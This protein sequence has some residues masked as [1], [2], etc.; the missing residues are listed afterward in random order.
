MKKRLPLALNALVFFVL[1]SVLSLLMLLTLFKLAVMGVPFL[2]FMWTYFGFMVL[3]VIF[4][5]KEERRLKLWYSFL[6]ALL[7]AAVL[8]Y[9]ITL[10][11]VGDMLKS[12]AVKVIL[13]VSAITAL[14]A[15]VALVI[16]LSRLVPKYFGL[17]V[18]GI[19]ALVQK[20]S[21]KQ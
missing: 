18:Q 5:E 19:K 21:D 6:C 9:L 4:L 13:A 14:A 17:T 15:L 12:T 1:F 10:G 7:T 2:V 11:L 16:L 8:V 3:E 20:K